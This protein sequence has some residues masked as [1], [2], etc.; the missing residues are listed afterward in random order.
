MSGARLFSAILALAVVLFGLVS[1]AATSQH[2]VSDPCA[3][4]DGE[5]HFRN[6]L[7][8][9]PNG[10]LRPLSAA[11]FVDPSGAVTATDIR[12]HT[13]VEIPC[14]GSFPI[15]TPHGALWLQFSVANPHERHVEWVLAFMET[16]IDEM[17]LYAQT[18]DGLVELARNG[19]IVPADEQAMGGAKSVLPLRM[20]PG[21]EKRLYLRV[22]GTFSEMMTPILASANF[23]NRWEAAFGS[24][25]AVL[26]GFT[27]MLAV[28]SAVLFRPVS[29]RFYK[30]YT[31]FMVTSFCFTF[32]YDG[33]LN[34]VFDVQF[35]VTLTVPLVELVAGL[36]VIANIQYCRVLLS[37][38]T[39]PRG[40]KT[41]LRMLTVLAVA[42]TCLAVVNPWS[43]ALGNHLLFFLSP[44]ILLI[45]AARR[46][47]DGLPQV[48]PVCAALL[49][50]ISGL[51]VANYFFVFPIALTA[52][53]SVFEVM[54]WRPGTFSYALA[55]MGEALFMMFAISTM[56]RAMRQR[57]ALAIEEANALRDALTDLKIQSAQKLDA[58]TAQ[59]KALTGIVAS[60][61]TKAFLS[62]ADQFADR[63]TRVVINNIALDGFGPR[64]LASDLA[65][66]QRTLSRR[67]KDARNLS[68]AAFIRMVRLEYA[69]DLILLQKRSSVA[70]VAQAAGFSSARHF[71][72]L[73]KSEFG[74]TP[75]ETF[76]AGALR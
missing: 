44:I 42:V 31:L 51:A 39:M 49:C 26:L 57:N 8:D 73:Y 50:L 25:S 68:P 1:S 14:T 18:Q 71:A 2:P 24:V 17:T 7:E 13:F 27:A 10:Q 40:Q 28:I 52:S 59:I 9:L 46:I 20:S 21:E 34:R 36:G 22:S 33:W 3:L 11:H 63:A 60:D 4:T 38:R 29:V 69:R 12:S 65:V 56:L 76:K 41:T 47:R 15:H 6:L 45:L 62:S 55:I 64:D 74:E 61:E 70:E 53:S 58:R 5:N 43:F 37:G 66:S 75:S 54:L 23:F 16:I 30:Y 67:L 72:K 32:F 48:V 19:R 35:P